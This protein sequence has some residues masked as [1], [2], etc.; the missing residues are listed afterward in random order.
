[1]CAPPPRPGL[2]AGGHPVVGVGPGSVA[3]PINLS[4]M[5]DPCYGG[6]YLTATTVFADGGIMH[7]S[8]GL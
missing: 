5:H 1:L 4:T 3:T 6:S 8:P 7:S 2:L